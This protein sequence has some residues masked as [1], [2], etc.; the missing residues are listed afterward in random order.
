MTQI[1]SRLKSAQVARFLRFTIP[2]LTFV[3]GVVAQQK[4]Q[5]YFQGP[6][7]GVLTTLVLV[8][9]VG[10]LSVCIG[11]MS[12]SSS[13]DLHFVVSGLNEQSDRT[14]ELLTTLRD[15]LGL[16]VTFLEDGASGASYRRAAELIRDAQES[17]TFVDY[18]EPYQDYQSE[19][20]GVPDQVADARDEY[21]SA[22]ELAVKARANSDLLFHRRVVQVPPDRI[23]QAIPFEVDPPFQDYLR[24]VARMQQQSPRSCRLRI[25]PAQIR[26]HFIMIDQRYI[27]LPILRTNLTTQRQGRLGALVFD[28][29]TG[30]LAH[31]L[32]NMYQDLESSSHAL[33]LVRLTSK[34]AA[35]DAGVLGPGMAHEA[36]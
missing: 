10:V 29:R 3:L 1:V 24:T 16:S 19:A 28:D 25:A 6:E 9:V 15:S 22:I 17:V 4:L 8:S 26:F 14:Q 35:P 23:N 21:Y 30:A 31:G 20:T 27:I 33:D 32:R 18:W 34:A 13:E 12:Y 36:T 7:S 11:V 2:A 5:E